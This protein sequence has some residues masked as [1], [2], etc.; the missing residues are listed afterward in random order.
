MTINRKNRLDEMQD[1][2][3]LKL[4]EAG[5]W[6]LF[7]ALSLSI[8]VQLLAGGSF[9]QIAGELIVLAIGSIW[10]AVTTLKNGLWTRESTPTRKGNA[11][12]SII[13][14]VLIGAVRVYKLIQR[15]W[16]QPK[17]LLIALGISAA[18]YVLCFGILEFFRAAYSKRRSALDDIPDEESEA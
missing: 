13:P 12:A 4:E 8:L 9:R 16:V 17:S 15:G 5:F 6:I 14:A 11:L 18:V 1:Q 3:L 10:L 2:K 7:W